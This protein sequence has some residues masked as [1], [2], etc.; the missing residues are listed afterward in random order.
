MSH[1]LLVATTALAVRSG[2]RV[3]VREVDVRNSGPLKDIVC[4]ANNLEETSQPIMKSHVI[5]E[6]TI[7]ESHHTEQKPAS[8]QQPRTKLTSQ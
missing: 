7:V 2:V 6:K 5:I 4:T 8:G 3:R 1:C